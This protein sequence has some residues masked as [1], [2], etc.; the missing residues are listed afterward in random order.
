[1]SIDT[2]LQE[3]ID[4]YR[5]RASEY[6]QWFLRLGRYDRGEEL[7]RAW[8]SEVGELRAWLAQQAPLGDTLELACGTGWWS[9]QLVQYASS[10]TA[11]DASP[12][13]P[14]LVDK[15]LEVARMGVGADHEGA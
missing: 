13:H 9:E 6:D 1:M 14:I 12:E 7:N 2:I 15:Y 4:Y 8:F 5:A 10:L 3:Q 11:V